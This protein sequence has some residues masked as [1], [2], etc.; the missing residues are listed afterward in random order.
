MRSPR[1][2]AAVELTTSSAD[3]YTAATNTYVQLAQVTATNKTGTLRNVT[4]T[5]TPSGGSARNVVYQQNAQLNVPTVLSGAIGL[6]LNP[7]DKISGLCSANS[8]VDLT[9]SGFVTS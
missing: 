8:A 5:I 3:L 7:G 2:L 1:L 9:I 6:V 4:L